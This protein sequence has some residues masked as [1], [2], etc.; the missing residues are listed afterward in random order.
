MIPYEIEHGKWIVEAALLSA[1]SC[2]TIEQLQSMFEQPVDLGT[3]KTWLLELKVDWHSRGVV[4]TESAFGFRFQTRACFQR[5]LERLNPEKP[6][7]YS[8]AVMETLAIIAYKQPVT[9]GDIEAIR[10]VAVASTVI[11]TLEDRG[12]IQAIGHRETVGRPTL[13]GTTKQFLSDLN[14][15]NLSALPALSDESVLAAL[16][17][18]SSSVEQVSLD[19]EPVSIEISAVIEQSV[20]SDGDV[21]IESDSRSA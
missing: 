20:S 4:L 5:Y 21:N 15:P 2:L 16:I 1:H 7:R 6:Q 9:R 13:F 14:L 11:K 18:D 10:G 12:W 19:Q 8:R 3:I 17:Q